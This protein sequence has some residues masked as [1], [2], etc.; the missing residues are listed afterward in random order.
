MPADPNARGLRWAA[1]GGGGFCN[2]TDILIM[3]LSPARLNGVG[4]QIGTAWPLDKVTTIQHLLKGRWLLQCTKS[5]RLHKGPHVENAGATI[6]GDDTQ[7]TILFR[8]NI[9]DSH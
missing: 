2:G 4:G 8:N 1:I 3:N 7:E 9:L 5:V 6:I